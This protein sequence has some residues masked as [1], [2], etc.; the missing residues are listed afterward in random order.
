V[1]YLIISLNG[2]EVQRRKLDQPLIVGR[3]LDCDVTIE[4]LKMSRRHCRFEP[5]E[6]NWAVVDMHSRNGTT[7]NGTPVQRHLLKDGDVVEFGHARAVFRA[8]KFA[9]PRPSDP[10]AA[11]LSESG[12]PIATG[13]KARE[14]PLPTPQIGR[15]DTVVLPPEDPE[16]RPLP[17]TRPPARPMVNPQEKEEEE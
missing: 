16:K 5:E 9:G 17:F 4:D 6:G 10:M 8:G 14:K 2:K 7:V 15:V 13:P 3:G 12:T 1:A 11:L